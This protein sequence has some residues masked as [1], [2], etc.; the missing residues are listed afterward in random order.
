MDKQVYKCV[1]LKGK[2]TKKK[3]NNNLLAVSVLFQRNG[4]V[5]HRRDNGEIVN[6]NSRTVDDSAESE[7]NFSLPNSVQP[8]L[9]DRFKTQ[10]GW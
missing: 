7:I 9:T 2:K 4:G 6:R 10:V 3:T 8:L 5:Y 1:R